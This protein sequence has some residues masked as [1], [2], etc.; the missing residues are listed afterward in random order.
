MRVIKTLIRLQSVRGKAVF[1]PRSTGKRS[2]PQKNLQNGKRRI[3]SAAYYVQ[4]VLF[5]ARHVDQAEWK[6]RFRPHNLT[7]FWM[8]DENLQASVGA[9]RR[10]LVLYGC[11]TS[12]RHG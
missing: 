11:E 2:S 7:N 9:V 12:G 3:Y 8:V 4:S 10:F 5:S 6:S 1:I